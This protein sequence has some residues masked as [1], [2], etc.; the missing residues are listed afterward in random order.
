MGKHFFEQ[1]QTSCDAVGGPN[2][3]VS[4]DRWCGLQWPTAALLNLLLLDV[5][6]VRQVIK[7]DDRRKIERKERKTL[8]LNHDNAVNDH[9]NTQISLK[10]MEHKVKVNENQLIDVQ[11]PL[12][13][14]DEGLGKSGVQLGGGGCSGKG[15]I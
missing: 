13:P 5:A 7:L 6:F 1:F 14:C 8:Q 15:L 12:L 11:V 2:H 4:T 10:E 9:M 3:C